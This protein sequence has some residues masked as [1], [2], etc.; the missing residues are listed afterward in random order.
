[1]HPNPL[2]LG[3]ARLVDPDE[4][5]E[6]D[7]LETLSW[8][9][10]D[11]VERTAHR[12]IAER[13]FPTNWPVAVVAPSGAIRATLASIGQALRRTGVT[14]GTVV[15]GIEV[16]RSKRRFVLDISGVAEVRVA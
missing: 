3:L 12:L 11:A 15:V 7:P 6:F 13:G 4:L 10:D 1:M 16:R 14:R 2:T 8:R 9:L 5:P